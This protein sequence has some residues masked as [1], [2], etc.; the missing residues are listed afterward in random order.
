MTS[1]VFSGRKRVIKIDDHTC[2][3]TL[4][5][6]RNV[7]DNVHANNAFSY[8]NNVYLKGDKFLKLHMLNRIL[9]SWPFHMKFMK[10]AKGSFHK[11]HIK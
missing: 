6:T 1:L 2:N 9:H 11:F 8:G 4:A 7:I 5:R 3:N 10:L